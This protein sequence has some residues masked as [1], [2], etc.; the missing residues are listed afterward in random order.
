MFHPLIRCAA[1]LSKP[2]IRHATASPIRNALASPLRS[3]NLS[4]L[5]QSSRIIRHAS[6]K[7]APKPALVSPITLTP[8][9]TGDSKPASPKPSP[10][11]PGQNASQLNADGTYPSRILLYYAGKRTVYLGTLKLYAVLLF[12]YC[13]LIVAPPLFGQD[14]A[15][16]L[17]KLGLDNAG[18]PGWVVPAAIVGGSLVPL[19]LFQWLRWVLSFPAEIMGEG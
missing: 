6:S 4:A 19:V 11:A 13:S 7:P 3:H 5:R 18:V 8:K 12:S 1:R 9:P 17:G 14:N 15:D 16:V 10:N 2:T